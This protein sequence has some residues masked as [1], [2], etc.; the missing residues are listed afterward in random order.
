[1]AVGLSVKAEALLKHTGISPQ[2]IL[3]IEGLDLIFGAQPVFKTLHWDDVSPEAI[4]DNNLRWD[5]VI[6]DSKSRDLIQLSGTTTNISQQIQPDKGSTSSISTVNVSLTD[7]NSEVSKAMSFDNIEEILG[8]KAIF[9]I[10]FKEGAYPEDCQKIFRGIITDFYYESGVVMC[11]ISSSESLK[12]QYFLPKFQTKLT[13]ELKYKQLLVQNILYKQ[14]LDEPGEIQI[15]YTSAASLLVAYDKNTNILNISFPGGTTAD[16]IDEAIRETASTF[17][18]VETEVIGDGTTVQVT[19]S[20]TT[21][22]TDTVVN[23]ESTAGI[24]EAADALTSYMRVNDEIMKIISLTDTT[25]SVER[26]QLDS[27]VDRHS[28][29]DDIETF[30]RLQG[31]PLD[32]AL[33]I[34]LST[35]GNEFFSSDDVPKAI[36][37]IS[38]TES[39]ENSVIFDYYDIQEKTGLTIGDTIQLNSGLNTGSYTIREFLIL[40]GGGS[41]IVTNETLIIE[42]EYTSDFKYISKWNTLPTGLEM[43]TSEVDVAQFEEIGAFFGSNFVDYD[44]YI[45]DTI[46]SA[47]DFIDK[48]IFYPQGLYGIPRK[49]RSSVK[50]VVPPFSN[51]V[52]ETIGQDHVTNITKIKQR[53]STH[54]YLYNTYVYRYNQDSIEDRFVT[55]K[56]VVST[57]S[58]ERIKIGKKQ[59]KIDSTGLRDNFETN[60]L[61]NAVSQRL[62]DRYQYSPV[63]L[64]GIELKYKD[65]YRLEVGDIIP[66]GAQTGMLNLQTGKRGAGAEL[67]EIT[68]KSLD[69]KS[70]K[71]RINLLNTNYEIAA[72]YGV[73]SLASDIDEGSTASRIIIKKTNDTGEYP[74][75]SDKWASFIGERVRIYSED[76]TFDEV[77]EL[78]SVDP[79]NKNA[80][81]LE[82][83]LSFVP[84]EGYIIEPPEYEDSSDEIDSDYKLQFCYMSSQEIITSVASLQEFDVNDSSRLQVGSAIYVHSEDYSRDSFDEP[85]IEI[86]SIIGN[87]VYLNKPLNFT[88]QVNDLVDGSNFKDGGYVYKI[89]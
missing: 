26:N 37:F 67:Y 18:A 36:N 14:R 60:S 27:F 30:Y 9:A 42:E 39:L 70:G 22:E 64:E 72:R 46:D 40:E 2:I 45:K 38:I 50:F 44:F 19:T 24:I 53:R 48:E 47:K 33:K 3:D 66:Y 58:T 28:L 5:G 16:Q 15:Q 1:M 25:I 71:I 76:Y 87:T 77:V 63:Y 84:G 82:T 6:E 59:L 49:A 68:N 10:G 32:L 7:K 12:R 65:G 89:I 54:K 41:A 73:F 29:D 20:L 55:G 85:P 81:N 62:I 21:V 57:N 11:T 78:K 51:Q 80:L 13:T 79:S 4:F 61:I 23:V 35:D 17:Y 56:I 88:P 86:D 83:P 31:A 75:E 8:K 69:V 74:R 43:L 52:T 34:M